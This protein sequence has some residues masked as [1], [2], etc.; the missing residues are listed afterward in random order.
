[1]SGRRGASSPGHHLPPLGNRH[2]HPRFS[3]DPDKVLSPLEDPVAGLSPVQ[4]EQPP[5]AR[6]PTEGLGLACKADL[7][8][9]APLHLATSLRGPPPNSCA[10][11]PGRCSRPLGSRKRRA[12]PSPCFTWLTRASPHSCGLALSCTA[13]AEQNV[14]SN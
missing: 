11:S 3:Y 7:P 4:K 2:N 5:P 9:R 6:S 1:M 14:F 12:V 10:V 13:A 8:H